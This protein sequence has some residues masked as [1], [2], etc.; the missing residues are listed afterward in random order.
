MG[1]RWFNDAQHSCWATK[2]D[3]AR[4]TLWITAGGERQDR[5]G[6]RPHDPAI[7]AAVCGLGDSVIAIG[8][9][10]AWARSVDS[11]PPASFVERPVFVRLD[12]RFTP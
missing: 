8:T 7:P 4:I 6:P 9:L 1:D 2:H 10:R 3:V 11:V 12:D 5:E